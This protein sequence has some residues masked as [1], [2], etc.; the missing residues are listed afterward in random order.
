M[1]KTLQ[2]IKDLYPCQNIHGLLCLK[3]DKDLTSLKSLISKN[4]KTLIVSEDQK[5]FLSKSTILAK[6]LE[7]INI[8]CNPVNSLKDATEILKNLVKDNSS[9]GLIFGSHYIAKEVFQAFE[10]DLVWYLL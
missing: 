9:I 4:F 10:M 2:T 8:K 1:K 6:E 5:G 7:M 3:K